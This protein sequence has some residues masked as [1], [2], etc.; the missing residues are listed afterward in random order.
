MSDPTA[1]PGATEETSGRCPA[2]GQPLTRL[3]HGH[4]PLCDYLVEEEPVTGPDLTP[5]AK[6]EGFGRR[7][8]W[9]TNKWVW[10]AGAERIA[11]LALMQDS[12]AARRFS[13]VNIGLFV[14]VAALCGLALGGWHA[15][16]LI[17]GAPEASPPTPSGQGWRLVVTAPTPAPSS[18]AAPGRIVAWWWN[19]PRAATT[20]AVAA[21]VAL[22]LSWL[23]L[24]LLR[25][26]VESAL[27]RRYRGQERLASALR[28]ST[29]W[30]IPLVPAGLILA[31]WPL[32][33][34]A[35]V[36][37]WS[38]QPPEAAAY[39]PAVVVAAFSL[40]LWWLGLIRLGLS[41]PVPTRRRVAVFVGLIMPLIAAGV[42]AGTLVG[43][44]RLRDLIDPHWPMHW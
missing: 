16:K 15:V 20:M 6:S 8:W 12:P 1:Y 43:L 35:A 32:W 39:V 33:R 7:A 27:R 14:T 9:S 23:L 13:R 41:V 2:C 24:A 44:L 18:R 42:I 38:V 30:A 28:Y 4:C 31:L 22:L 34:V 11:H 3:V 17:P 5:Y 40:L 19:L 29:A 25:T 10:S 26:G 36:G 37:K 21:V